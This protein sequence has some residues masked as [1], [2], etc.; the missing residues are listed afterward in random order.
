MK[1][2]RQEKKKEKKKRS[3]ACFE[4][5]HAR[6]YTFLSLHYTPMGGGN[7]GNDT[8]F[9]PDPNPSHGRN[10]KK[11]KK[12]KPKITKQ[13][14]SFFVNDEASDSFFFFVSISIVGENLK[15]K[16]KK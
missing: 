2:G 16:V 5:I 10:W 4:M 3:V 7:E 9:P 8:T 15:K 14:I 1:Q 6:L 12:K 11:K 13:L